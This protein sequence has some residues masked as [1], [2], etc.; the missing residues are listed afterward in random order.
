[1]SFQSP[2]MPLVLFARRFEILKLQFHMWVETGFGD[3]LR[4][5]IHRH[6]SLET[7]LFKGARKNTK[8]KKTHCLYVC[9]FWKIYLNHHP[10][11]HPTIASGTISRC[12]YVLQRSPSSECFTFF[13]Q[14]TLFLAT[15]GR[16]NSSSS[17]PMH[18]SKIHT[19]HHIPAFSTR[20]DKYVYLQSCS[21][22]DESGNLKHIAKL[23]ILMLTSIPSCIIIPTADIS[24]QVLGCCHCHLKDFALYSCEL[25]I[26]K[27]HAS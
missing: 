24:C 16:Q 15:C 25:Q 19:T 13:E 20:W 1:M 4:L 8:K 26:S 12:I 9:S 11:R 23:L 2:P 5:M 14:F 17:L 22:T 18:W 7:C 27:W 6:N 3:S 21:F 10:P